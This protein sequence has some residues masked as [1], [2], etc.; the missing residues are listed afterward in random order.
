MQAAA[1]VGSAQRV[2]QRLQAIVAQTAADEPIVAGA[3][4]NHA[5]RLRSHELLA[6]AWG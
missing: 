5:A 3:T 6:G 1:A 2:K 4:H